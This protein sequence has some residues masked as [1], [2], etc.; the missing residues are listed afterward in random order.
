MKTTRFLIIT[1]FLLCGLSAAGQDF[2]I[3][4]RQHT[5][6]AA[7][8]Y[9]I[10][11]YAQ[12]LNPS[13]DARY[14][15]ATIRLALNSD[16]GL[17][18]TGSILDE[19]AGWRDLS[20]NYSQVTITN[21]LSETTPNI[22]MNWAANASDYNA[23]I[24]WPASNEIRVARISVPL[25]DPTR[26]RTLQWYANPSATAAAAITPANVILSNNGHTTLY[27]S[28]VIDGG[29]SLPIVF[30]D[31]TGQAIKNA[32]KLTWTTLSES[33]NAGFF[34]ERMDEGSSDWLSLFFVKGSGT[35]TQKMSYN[36]VDTD[37]ISG[38]TVMYR[39][40]QRDFNGEEM[41][42]QVIRVHVQGSSA[43]HLVQ[44]Y[45]NPF[46]E[47]TQ[48]RYEIDSPGTAV[49]SVFDITGR[50]ISTVEHRHDRQG[51]YTYFFDA[52]GLRPGT[53][54]YEVVFGDQRE[55]GKMT[56]AR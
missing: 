42:S 33:N 12:R 26:V 32:V 4:I 19:S 38:S 51:L 53:Y 13:T 31:F 54:R 24:S 8:K 29:P 41:Y 30:G 52:R 34:I 18:A 5:D 48:I 43:L 40:R 46:T 3:V 15:G 1:L 23:C 10:E 45:P 6:V 16:N 49:I 20:A 25:V 2:G 7:S 14:R 39:L 21:K 17:L 22:I 27:F 36:Y 55:S 35:T 56:L 9:T 47:S 11:V 37:V 44:N 50:K 28:F